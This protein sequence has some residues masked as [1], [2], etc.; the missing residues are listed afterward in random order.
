MRMYNVSYFSSSMYQC[1]V[2]ELN[3]SNGV[4]D[5]RHRRTEAQ[6]TQKAK[7]ILNDVDGSGGGA[8]NAEKYHP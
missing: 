5:D 2:L 7:T 4:D 6:I 8:S 3:N 1:Y